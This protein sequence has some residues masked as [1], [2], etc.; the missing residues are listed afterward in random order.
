VIVGNVYANVGNGNAS[1]ENVFV[2]VE[3]DGTPESREKE[4]T[5]CLSKKLRSRSHRTS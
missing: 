3:N 2:S 4:Y 1:V 5:S